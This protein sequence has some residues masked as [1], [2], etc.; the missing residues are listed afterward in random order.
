MVNDKI[1]VA[2]GVIM[3]MVKILPNKLTTTRANQVIIP[4]DQKIQENLRAIEL[5]CVCV[6][7]R[8]FDLF[9]QAIVNLQSPWVNLLIH[10]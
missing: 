6:A 10:N 7:E 4:V 9:K 8:L 1:G 3:N 2:P 5:C